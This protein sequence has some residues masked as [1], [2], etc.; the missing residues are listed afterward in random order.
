MYVG[1]WSIVQLLTIPD[2][3][4]DCVTDQNFILVGQIGPDTKS[5]KKYELMVTQITKVNIDL[6]RSVPLADPP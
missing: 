1:Y 2:W 5:E 6:S 3:L 4:L